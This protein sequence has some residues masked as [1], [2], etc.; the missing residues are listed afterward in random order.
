[1]VPLLA[2]LFALGVICGAVLRLVLFVAVMIAAGAAVALGSLP[3]GGGA[4]A[5]N[6]VIAIVAMQLG[7]VGGMAGRARL[8]AWW[9]GRSGAPD[10]QRGEAGPRA[11]RRSP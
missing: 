8:G 10:A 1:M 2:G 7:Y 4:A 3:Q 11:G 5:L 9:H 6:A